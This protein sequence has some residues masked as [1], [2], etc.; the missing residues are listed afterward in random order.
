M[1]LM[2]IPIIDLTPYREGSDA[3]KQAVAAAV[4]Q[5]CR[6]I[7]FLVITG[8]G[9]SPALVD[10][11]DT[12]S[13]AFFDLPGADKMALKRPKDDQVRGYSAVGDEGLSYSLGEK[14]PGDLKESFS[15]G[16][17]SVPDDPYFNGP[18]AGPHF[19]PNL[20]APQI[21]DFEQ[22]W[23]EYFEAMSELSKTLMRV[24]ALGLELPETYFDDKIDRHISMFRALK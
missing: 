22:S 10:R 17:V 18:A 1:T 16:P 5:A 15:I 12:T 9:V 21:P 6:D 24:F 20:W 11:V 8:H 2:S 19:A 4:A 7:G 23:K 14:T 3:G 13:R